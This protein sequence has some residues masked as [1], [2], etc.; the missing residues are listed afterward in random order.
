MW[1]RNKEQDVEKKREPR[2]ERKKETKERK[3]DESTDTA[4]QVAQRQHAIRKWYDMQMS[5]NG[6]SIH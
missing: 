4:S 3:R 5:A 1:G 2:K 6:F